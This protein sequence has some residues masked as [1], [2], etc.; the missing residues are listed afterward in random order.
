M[1]SKGTIHRT[2]RVPDEIWL[3]AKTKADEEGRNLSDIIREALRSYL[4]RD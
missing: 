3:P 2:V 4:E 1:P